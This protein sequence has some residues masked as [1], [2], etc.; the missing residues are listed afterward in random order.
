MFSSRENRNSKDMAPPPKNGVPPALPSDEDFYTE[1]R[2]RLGVLR[3]ELKGVADAL[4]DNFHARVR[5]YTARPG[6]VYVPLQLSTGGADALRIRWGAAHSRNG[7]RFNARAVKAHLTTL[8]ALAPEELHEVIEATEM[9]LRV[10]RK[11]QATIAR[12]DRL[13]RSGK[14]AADHDEFTI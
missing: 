5:A 6:S 11:R 13:V 12:I 8:R 2:E 14:A 7:K 10:I 3:R 9:Q 4:R 1:L